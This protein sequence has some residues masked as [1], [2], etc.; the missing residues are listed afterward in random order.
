MIFRENLRKIEN[1]NEV[2]QNDG[3]KFSVNKFADLT[4]EEFK[5]SHRNYQK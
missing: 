4:E 2:Y 3:V 5:R 1:L